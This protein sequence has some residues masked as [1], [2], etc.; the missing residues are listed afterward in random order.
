M[1]DSTLVVIFGYPASNL[2]IMFF[3]CGV[4][5]F[6]SSSALGFWFDL[7]LSS[8]CGVRCIIIVDPSVRFL[9]HLVPLI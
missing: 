6:Y 9:A 8:G 5:I 2:Y 4:A 7:V 1:I 3:C